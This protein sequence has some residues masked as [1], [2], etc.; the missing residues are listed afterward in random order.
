[1]KIFKDRQSA[2]KLLVERLKNI[3]AD[4]VLGIPRG[5]VVVAAKIANELNLPLD[6]VVTRKIGAPG[7]E[8]L[9]LGAVDPDG[10]V[11]WDQELLD[12]LK[13]KPE[14]LKQK[15]GTEIKELKRREKL[16]RQGRP[17]LDI[18]G[19]TVILTDDGMATG[20]TTLAAVKYLKRHGAKIILAIPVTSSDALRKVEED[21]E[22]SIILEIPEYFQAVGQFYHEFEAVSDEEVIQLL[23]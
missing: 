21:V 4:L 15:I 19:K 2:G 8:E 7:Q 9:A 5:G 11:V 16:Y 20:S 14:D 10:E 13:I 17:S 18:S 1:M 22:D 23:T 12:E 6:I 3:K